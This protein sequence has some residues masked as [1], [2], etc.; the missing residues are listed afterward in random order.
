MGSLAGE[1]T[2]LSGPL[3]IERAIMLAA[4]RALEELSLEDCAGFSREQIADHT[5]AMVTAVE[6]ARVVTS[7]FMALSETGASALT[8]GARSMTALVNDRCGV[9]RRQGSLMDLIG[10]APNRYVLFYQALLEGRI[11]PGHIEVLHPVWRKVD[12]EH[13]NA[14]ERA[15]V[16]LAQRCTPEE[17]ADYLAQWRS[18]ADENTALHEY[19]ANQAAQHCRYGFDLFGNVHYS[20]TVGPEHAEPFVETIETEAAN[21]KTGTKKPSQARGDAVVELILNPDGKY[22]AHL[23]VLVPEHHAALSFGAASSVTEPIPDPHD[24]GFSKVYWPRTASGT[25]IPPVIVERMRANGARVTE[26]E[27]NG[28]GDITRDLPGTRHF[29]EVQKR[30]IRLRD[31]RCQH[32]GCRRR[33]RTCEYDH[34]EPAE[35]GGPTLIRNGQLLCRFHHRW[36]H[37]ND[38]GLHRPTI[39]DDKPLVQLE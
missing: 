21:H 17:F 20:G 28:D 10:S 23:E 12:R 37:R 26:H 11:G 2:E 24:R 8:K 7:R 32:P 1:T 25:L 13:F 36:K 38:R 22:R 4:A 15:L 5:V 14:S 29:G 9:T 33:S 3:A 6:R 16:D 27:V 34:I 31:N 30:L 18:H 35:H 39:F 19:I